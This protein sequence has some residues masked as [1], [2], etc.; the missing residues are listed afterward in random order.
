MKSKHK[1]FV[2]VR[3]TS[4]KFSFVHTASNHHNTRLKVLYVVSSAVSV[5][6]GDQ[7]YLANGDLLR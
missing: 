5:N 2:N 4:A 1:H 7:R 6:V 3:D